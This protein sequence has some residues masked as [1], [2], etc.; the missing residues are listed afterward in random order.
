MDKTHK[1]NVGETVCIGS[2]RRL[3]IVEKIIIEEKIEIERGETNHSREINY[4]VHPPDPNSGIHTHDESTLKPSKKQLHRD[5]FRV[6]NEQ[7]ILRK[8]IEY[9]VEN[10]SEIIDYQSGV[11]MGEVDKVVKWHVKARKLSNG[12]YNPTGKLINFN[13]G[14]EEPIDILRELKIS[15]K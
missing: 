3:G 6:Q 7:V 10:A 1:Y 9:V 5:A 2:N 14:D 12:K 13:Q 4:D 8:G 11:R 15:Y